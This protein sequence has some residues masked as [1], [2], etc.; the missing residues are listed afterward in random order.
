MHLAEDRAEIAEV[1]RLFPDA[2]DYLDVYDR[3][4]GLGPRSILAHAIHLSDREV[5]RLAETGTHLAHCP[6]SNLFL[7]SGSC[8]SPAIS[9]RA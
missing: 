2:R 3:G 4:G 1:G 5:G 7:A 8:P 6:A 9:R